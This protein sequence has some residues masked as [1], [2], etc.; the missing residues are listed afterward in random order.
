MSNQ[1]IKVDV[2]QIMKEIRDEIQKKGLTHDVLSFQDISGKNICCSLIF[3]RDE[4]KKRMCYL[5]NSNRVE[6]F[7]QIIPHRGI[8]NIIKL[9]IR[10]CLRFL[11]QPLIEEQNHY[12][13]ELVQALNQ[14]QLFVEEQIRQ[15]EDYRNQI[16]MIKKQDE[17]Q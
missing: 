1:M 6:Y 12:N 14:M 9:V 15:N 11:L 10:K 5:N 3:N 2:E 7:H 13:A 16:E 4:L 8:K 17:G